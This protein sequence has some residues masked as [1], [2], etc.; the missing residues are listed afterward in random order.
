MISLTISKAS[1]ELVVFMDQVNLKLYK[2]VN[3]EKLIKCNFFLDMKL[4]WNEGRH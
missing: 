2:R 1:I 3:D 4:F